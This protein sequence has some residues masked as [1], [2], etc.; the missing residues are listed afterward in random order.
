MEKEKETPTP[1]TQSPASNSAAAP[2]PP[3]AGQVRPLFVGIGG[4]TASGKT[5]LCQYLF[6][7]ISKLD[8]ATILSFDNFYW[9]PK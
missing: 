1:V 2:Q 8:N 6:A 9:G 4:G 7:G 3:P 5:T